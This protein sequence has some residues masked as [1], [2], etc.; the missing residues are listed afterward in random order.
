MGTN[1]FSRTR[2]VAEQVRRDLAEILARDVA[3]PRFQNLTLST[4]KVAQDL[5]QAK[6]YFTLPENEDSDKVLT[7]LRRASGY[8]RRLLSERIT[9]RTTPKLIFMYDESLEQAHRISKLLDSANNRN[10]GEN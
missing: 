1:D 5:S 9:L 7:A 10:R 6:V 2:R 8:L 4:V 3:D